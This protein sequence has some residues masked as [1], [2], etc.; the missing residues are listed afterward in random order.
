MGEHSTNTAAIW[1]AF[2]TPI[3]LGAALCSNL[4]GFVI[5]TIAFFLGATLLGSYGVPG[6]LRKRRRLRRRQRGL[7]EWCE[8]PIGDFAIC[9][10]CGQSTGREA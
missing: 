6:F 1:A 3:L 10:E 7:C 2:L 5:G 8:Y 9:P 4:D